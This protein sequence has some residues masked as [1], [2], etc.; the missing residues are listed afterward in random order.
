VHRH[1]SRST[2]TNNNP[3]GWRKWGESGRQSGSGRRSWRML[4][5]CRL[6]FSVFGAVCIYQCTCGQKRMN[7][8][9]CELKMEK[10]LG[11]NYG[12]RVV[13][14]R[15]KKCW[16]SVHVRHF[17]HVPLFET[18][19]RLLFEKGRLS[20]KESNNG[21]GSVELQRNGG[22]DKKKGQETNLLSA[23]FKSEANFSKRWNFSNVSSASKA[24]ELAEW[25]HRGEGVVVR[26]VKEVKSGWKSGWKAGGTG[27]TEWTLDYG[28]IAGD[29]G[30]S[31]EPLRSAISSWSF[32]GHKTIKGLGGIFINRYFMV[33]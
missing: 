7:E 11:E 9:G 5:A 25:S 3:S 23:Q 17:K 29:R 19:R 15:G 1:A 6:L 13:A 14:R 16:K 27:P 18:F 33:F 10:A 24:Q 31:T 8:R 12:E 20:L 22:Q 4:V 26:G 30:P 2:A 32:S 28:E 21:T